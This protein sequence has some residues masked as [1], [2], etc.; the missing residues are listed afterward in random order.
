MSAE[1]VDMHRGICFPD[2]DRIRLLLLF[3]LWLMFLFPGGGPTDEE[4]VLELFQDIPA[5]VPGGSG[6]GG[7]RDLP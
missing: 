2:E 7:G 5:D 3:G 6:G 1:L 4:R